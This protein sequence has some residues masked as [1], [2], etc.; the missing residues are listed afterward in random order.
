MSEASILPPARKAARPQRPISPSGR[1]AREIVETF[2][3]TALVF[4]V[5]RVSMQ[6]Y[7]VVGPSMQP[8]MFTGEDVMVNTL[9]YLFGGPARGDVIVFHPPSDLSTV[10]VKRVIGVPGDR[11]DISL[12]AVYVDGVKLDEPYIYPLAPGEDEN[13][14]VFTNIQL[15]ANQYYVMGDHRQDSTDSRAFGYVPRQNIIGKAEAVMWPLND[16]HFISTY[17]YVFAQVKQT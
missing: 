15:G 8:G 2:I 3:L 12:D 7:E 6:P 5:I 10:Y 1:V 16:A 11:I 13:N 4:L 17:S 9:A 14:S